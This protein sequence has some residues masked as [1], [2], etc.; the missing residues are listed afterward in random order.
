MRERA[1]FLWLI[2]VS[3]P[4]TLL[5]NELTFYDNDFSSV[6]RRVLIVL[7][8]NDIDIDPAER[9]SVTQQFYTGLI[10]EGKEAKQSKMAPRRRVVAESESESESE[11][12]QQ[13]TPS[14]PS[15]DALEKALRDVVTNIYKSGNMKELT[16]KRVR[17][18]AEKALGVK[19]WF[20]KGSAI[21]KSKSDQIIKDEVEAQDKQTQG[22]GSDKE[23]EEE[24]E[25]EEE[26]K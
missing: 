2:P 5:Q 10:R 4:A 13:T 18:A 16:V 15:D 8:V 20:F 22:S 7:E 17:A 1:Q 25:E 14:V 12:D 21:W 3:K 23:E 24:E 9:K 11:P 26:V 6:P 19:E